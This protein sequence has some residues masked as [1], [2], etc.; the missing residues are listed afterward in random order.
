[1][2]PRR[3]REAR[4]DAPRPAAKL[5]TLEDLRSMDEREV[6]DFARGPLQEVLGEIAERLPARGAA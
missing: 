5:P 1:M 2:S 4:L 6:L 3:N